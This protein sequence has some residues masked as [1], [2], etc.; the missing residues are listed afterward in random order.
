MVYYAIVVQIVVGD[1]AIIGDIANRGACF[2]RIGDAVTVRM[3][4]RQLPSESL[5]LFR[6]TVPIEDTVEMFNIGIE[7]IH[8]AVAVSIGGAAVSGC[9]FC[10]R[11][12][13]I[14]IR[15]CGIF[16]GRG[17]AFHKVTDAIVVTIQIK[18]IRDAIAIGIF[19]PLRCDKRML[20]KFISLLY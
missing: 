5:S 4:S 11:N 13:A 12:C 15:I 18:M 19:I 10:Q 9:G 2:H 20:S 6:G 16:G 14:F 7:N 8:Q 3:R 17:T 1:I